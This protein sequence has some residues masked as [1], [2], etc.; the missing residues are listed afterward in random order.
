MTL[1]IRFYGSSVIM[2]YCLDSGLANAKIVD[3]QNIAFAIDQEGTDLCVLFSLRC[4]ISELK[5]FVD[6]V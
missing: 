4:L 6:R 5:N 3:F 2:A 1:G